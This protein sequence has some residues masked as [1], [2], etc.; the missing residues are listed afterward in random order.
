MAENKKV[1]LLGNSGSGKSNTLGILVGDMSL[2][3]GEKT[4]GVN[5]RTYTSDSGCQ[6]DI[7]DCA[8]YSSNRGLDDGYYISAD[9]AII[10]GGGE[11]Y[12][13]TE[14]WKKALL[15]VVPEA[16]I[17]VLNKAKATRVKKILEKLDEAQ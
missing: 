1:V 12:I 9:I 13:T 15:R 3:T 5:V 10:F 6:F 14:R 11:K 17:F 2:C 8:G 4:V 7:W 16:K